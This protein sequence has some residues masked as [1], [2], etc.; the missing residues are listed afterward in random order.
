MEQ[1]NFKLEAVGR[2]DYFVNMNDVVKQQER[3]IKISMELLTIGN[4]LEDRR[5]S[6]I[7][8]KLSKMF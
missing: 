5:Y 7:K 8:T 1:I 4:M 6:R 3:L 2:E